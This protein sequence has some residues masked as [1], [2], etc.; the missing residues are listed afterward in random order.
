M[1]LT[2]TMS[3]AAGGDF[4]QT[5]EAGDIR[6]AALGADGLRVT[7]PKTLAT[8]KPLVLKVVSHDSPRV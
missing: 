6:G 7:R 2:K 1:K 4:A 5:L 3:K 8:Q